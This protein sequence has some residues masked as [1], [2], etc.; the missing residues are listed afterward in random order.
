M[1]IRNCL[2]GAVEEA[3][4]IWTQ[5]DGAGDAACSKSAHRRSDLPVERDGGK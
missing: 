4:C 2:K 1:R 3:L 5:R